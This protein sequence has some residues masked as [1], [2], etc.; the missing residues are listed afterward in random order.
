MPL[1]VEHERALAP[2]RAEC[3]VFKREAVRASAQRDGD[4]A[5]HGRACREGYVQPPIEHEGCKAVHVVADGVEHAGVLVRAFEFAVDAVVAVGNQRRNHDGRRC[6][7]ARI[8]GAHARALFLQEWRQTQHPPVVAV[9]QRVDVV[10]LGVALE[11]LDEFTQLL[12]LVRREVVAFSR[13]G[14]QVE[15]QPLVERNGRARRL[16]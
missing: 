13:V 9:V 8:E 6:A 5:L 1:A 12:R 4:R 3:P 16:Q 15:Q 7:G 11:G 14:M 2:A 10:R